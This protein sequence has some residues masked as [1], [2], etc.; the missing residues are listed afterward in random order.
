MQCDVFA[1][2]FLQHAP[3]TVRRLKVQLARQECL[4]A[5]NAVAAGRESAL[6][7]G[8]SGGK[9]SES[10]NDEAKQT[11]QPLKGG[12][13]DIAGHRAYA[14]GNARLRRGDLDGARE[15]LD[16]AARRHGCWDAFRLLTLLERKRGRW[17]ACEV[18]AQ[19][20]LMRA[21][22][23]ASRFEARLA[24]QECR[25]AAAQ[26][27][28]GL[29]PS[30]KGAGRSKAA[31]IKAAAYAGGCTTKEGHRAYSAG[32]RQMTGGDVKGARRQLYAAA[33]RHRCW[34]A[35]RL[36][37]HMYA[38]NGRWKLCVSYADAFL[39]RAPANT[40]QKEARSMRRRCV[41][42]IKAQAQGHQ[43]SP[44]GLPNAELRPSRLS[45][46]LSARDAY[47]AGV[48][49]WRNRQLDRAHVLLAHALRGGQRRALGKLAL[50]AEL[51]GRAAACVAYGRAYIASFPDAG[52]AKRMAAVVKR[53]ATK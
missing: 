36:L 46:S 15:R 19:N 1:S 43:P 40:S 9:H 47:Q 26:S 16:R 49:A 32:S 34:D 22:A 21:P 33:V 28:S 4:R 11:P 53:C 50:I 37:A 18:Y 39:K 42:S 17:L 25:Q 14:A 20:Y 48:L 51:S 44:S 52:D 6:R 30:G 12:C 31:G 35:Y 27:R 8:G 24:Q 3:A 2:A 23:G 38:R 29:G 5:Q 41:Q 13:H 7:S 10:R 45:P